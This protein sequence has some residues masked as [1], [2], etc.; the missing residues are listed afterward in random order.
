MHVHYDHRAFTIGG[1]RQL[2]VSGAIHYP[3]STPAMWPKLMKESVAAGLNTIETYLFWNLH[4][5]RRGVYDFTGRLDVIR[6]CQIAQ[7]HGL[8]VILRIGPYICAEINYGGF[9]AWLRDIPGI[10]MRTWNEPFMREMSRW[11]TYVTD[12][13]RPLFAPNG[14]PI[15]AAQIENEYGLLGG[16]YGEEGE[17]YKQWSADLGRSLGIGVP[18]IMCYGGAAGA[19]ETINGFYGHQQLDRHWSEHPDQPAIWTEDWPGWYD[20]WG[21]PHHR[22]STRDVAYAVARFFAAGGTGINHYMWH[23]GTNFGREAMYLQTTSYDYDAP[24]DEFGLPTTK[25]RALTR[26]HQVLHKYADVILQNERPIPFEIGPGHVAFDYGPLNF[27][28]NDDPTDAAELTWEGER[29]TLPPQSVTIFADGQFLLNTAELAAAEEIHREM[30][31][32]DAD[33]RDWAWRAEPLPVDRPSGLVLDRP[34]EQLSL[35]RDETDYCWYTTRFTVPGGEATLTL[36]GVGDYVYIYAD[37]VPATATPAPL[38]EVR[39]ALDGEGFTQTFRLTL[40]PGEHELS[41]LCCAVGLI[42][43]DWQIGMA[44]MAEERKGFWGRALLN[45]EPLTGPWELRPGLMGERHALY[46]PLGFGGAPSGDRAVGISPTAPSITRAADPAPPAG[47]IPA[48]PAGAIPAPPAGAIPVSQAMSLPWV[49]GAAAAGQPLRWWKATFD[50][51][52]GDAPLALDLGS[53]NKGLAWVN[54]RCI[55]RYWL[56]PGTGETEP[57]VKPPVEDDW[58]GQPTQRYYHVP[59]DWLKPEGNLL[60]LFEE[61]G[62]DPT[63]IRLCG[64]VEA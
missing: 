54:G 39:G 51:P 21:T 16:I 46:R 8:N 12:L 60:V 62:G 23:G 6:F 13:L 33:L 53:M 50:R 2:I 61:A 22:R 63:A 43:G 30:L 29:Y 38:P 34:V 26:L 14:G 42:K 9:P 35:T 58:V 18:W 55:G 27:L 11:V 56:I 64:W 5:P 1:E 15:I 32:A 40:T 19:L 10:R 7:E 59:A 49:P 17:R 57:W 4:E 20:T 25:S 28:C 44:N 36:E 48:P 3:R 52:T 24:L 47:A 45:D 37:G 41:L 31:P